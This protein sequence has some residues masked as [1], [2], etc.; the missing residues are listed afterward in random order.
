M[1]V[2]VQLGD[3]KSKVFYNNKYVILQ[4]MN[5]VAV[6]PHS[7][8]KTI[9]DIY[10]YSNTYSRRRAIKH[11]NR[12]I[13]E[14]RSKPGDI[15]ICYPNIPE[16]PIIINIFGQFYMGGCNSVWPKRILKQTIDEHL[17]DGVLNDTKENRLKWFKEGLSEIMK[18]A[19]K[20]KA[21]TIF[22]PE[23][24]GCNAGGG[25]W[26]LYEKAIDDFYIESNLDFKILRY[27]EKKD[28]DA[29]I[30]SPSSPQ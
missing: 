1:K 22:I 16:R 5:C 12:A 28:D 4:I 8:S 19:D 29:I 14:D 10:P 17:R 3:F 27:Q 7:L 11:F 13:I 9:A 23:Y 18:N 25:D 2:P 30:N 24:I 20:F 15:E 21:K 6:K 26:T